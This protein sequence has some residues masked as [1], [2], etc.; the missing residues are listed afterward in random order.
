MLFGESLA[1]VALQ[2]K[3]NRYENFLVLML[4]SRVQAVFVA[5]IVFIFL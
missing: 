1:V 2:L 5:F 4:S 3:S